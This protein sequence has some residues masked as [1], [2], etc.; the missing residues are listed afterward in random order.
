MAK[1]KS[2]N[3][4]GAS[5]RKKAG[6]A[7]AK[8]PKPTAEAL[9]D[10]QRQ[11]LLFNHK[12]KIVPLLEAEKVAKA[13]VAH[14]YEL[15]KKEGI[16]KKD[17]KLAIQL[18]SDEG[19]EAAKNDLERT[20]RIAHWLGVGKQMSLFGDNETVAQRHYEDGRRAALN[21]QPAKPPSH[22]A[23]KDANTWLEGH[24]TG[25]TSLNES[26]AAGF[27]PLGDTVNDLMDKAGMPVA[28]NGDAAQADQ[29]PVH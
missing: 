9:S 22:L 20:N 26:R 11:T 17:I 7:K 25:R 24:A 18:T 16:P 14:A 15:A 21:D 19:I 1:T 5:E 12:R 8:S 10:Q 28:G 6:K 23:T 4:K 3:G 27:R 13:A 2:K 29:A